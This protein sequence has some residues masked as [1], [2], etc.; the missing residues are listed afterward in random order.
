MASPTTPTLADQR[1]AGERFVEFAV[2]PEGVEVDYADANGVRVMR[3]T[4]VDAD[5]R[6]VVEYFHGGGYQLCSP[7]S[8]RRLAA[9]IAKAAGAVAFSVDFRLTPEHGHPA[10]VE[11]SLTVY[12][13]LLDCG[14]AAHEIALVGDSSGGGLAL[15]TVMAL[16]EDSRPLPVAVVAISPWTDMSLSGSSLSSRAGV[17]ISLTPE[18]L[19]LLRDAFVAEDQRDDPRASPLSGDPTGLPPVYLQAGDAE[20]LRDDAVRF[21]LKASAVGV[22]VTFDIVP[23]MQHVFVKA[24]GFLPDAD[25]GVARV[26]EFLR[27]AF[28]ARVP[29]A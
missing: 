17:D 12:Q 22:D 24:A 20:L 1:A 6:R 25:A 23:E 18:Y 19:T 3:I 15:G 7:E 2:E 27:R 29:S 14:Y 21:G 11:D 26:G 13:W 4:P 16:K 5:K 9:H 8:H 28:A 10:Q